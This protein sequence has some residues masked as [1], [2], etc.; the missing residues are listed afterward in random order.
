MQQF[1]NIFW[2][3]H[4]PNAALAQHKRLPTKNPYA[5]L[6]QEGADASVSGRKPHDIV[7]IERSFHGSESV[8]TRTVGF[9]FF[10]KLSWSLLERHLSRFHLW[11]FLQ[12]CA[13]A[14]GPFG[15]E[16]PRPPE[17]L[18]AASPKLPGSLAAA[19]TLRPSSR[20]LALDL[21]EWPA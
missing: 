18:G 10:D 7:S 6:P 12:G 5:L 4:L 8:K 20:G 17:L 3:C 13:S 1:L 15:L 9:S 14:L 11:I 16:P 19:F 21:V 2:N